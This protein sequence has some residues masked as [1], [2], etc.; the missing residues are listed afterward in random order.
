[1]RSR[2]VDAEGKPTRATDERGI[3]VDLTAH[4]VQ[5]MSERDPGSA[6]KYLKER[7][8]QIEALKE[9]E[10]EEDDRRRFEQHF[11]AAGGTKEGAKEA[12]IRK[13]NEEAEKAVV[14]AN[15]AALQSARDRVNR[16]V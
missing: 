6:A 7:R 4:D 5:R 16:L 13:R 3:L 10:R 2:A 9:R 1:M 12:L 8:Q 15:E 14:A 11:V